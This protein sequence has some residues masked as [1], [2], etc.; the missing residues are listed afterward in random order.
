MSNE[1]ADEENVKEET[2]KTEDGIEPLKASIAE[3]LDSIVLSTVRGLL[4]DDA[5]IRDSAKYFKLNPDA[6]FSNLNENIAEFLVDPKRFQ[7]WRD[8]HQRTIS[9]NF[10]LSKNYK[11]PVPDQHRLTYMCQCA[12]KMDV[13]K[14]AVERVGKPEYEKKGSRRVALQ[15]SMLCSG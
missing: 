12:G 6:R 4:Y 1:E 9:T 13:R 7:V 2:I 5:D 3:G 10:I 8:M 15:E 11:Y 14:D